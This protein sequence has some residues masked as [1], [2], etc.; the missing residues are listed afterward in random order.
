LSDDY[1]AKLAEQLAGKPLRS[2]LGGA[3]VQLAVGFIDRVPEEIISSSE[4]RHA[5][6]AEA[7]AHD[8]E[9]TLNE[10]INSLL[11]G[12]GDD[13][14][15]RLFRYSMYTTDKSDAQKRGDGEASILYGQYLGQELNTMSAD[16]QRVA[17]RYHRLL[18]RLS[19]VRKQ[20]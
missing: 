1:Q 14:K 4:N 9:V 7:L 6:D 8:E 5:V 16:A 20:R 13:D 11:E 12:L 10:Q 2:E 15:G 3:A 17:D 19:V 18:N